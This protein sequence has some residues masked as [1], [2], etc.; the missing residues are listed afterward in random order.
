MKKR[1]H[2]KQFGFEGKKGVAAVTMVQTADGR[3][4]FFHQVLDTGT[5]AKSIRHGQSK[6]VYIDGELSPSEIS[7]VKNQC[8]ENLSPT[9]PS[10]QIAPQ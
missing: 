7:T 5:K 9:L 3:V 4:G 10:S 1:L 2:I 6:P 8:C